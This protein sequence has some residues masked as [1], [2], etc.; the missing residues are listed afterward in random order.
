MSRG[1]Q[2]GEDGIARQLFRCSL[3][4]YFIGGFLN[5]TVSLLVP[6]LRLL[7][8]LSY[9]EALLVNLAFYSSYVIFALPASLAVVRLGYM[10][11]IAMGLAV[12]APGC[13]GLAL[14]Q[15]SNSF[16]LTLIALLVL[17]AGATALQIASNSV[18]TI[19]GPSP[20]AAARLTF[21]QAFNSLGT[22]LGPVLCAP[23]I[24]T[25]LAAS[26]GSADRNLP[27]VP[28][29]VATVGLVVLAMVFLGNRDL[30]ARAP[31]AR[32]LRF[33]ASAGKLVRDRRLMAG[34]AAIFAYVGAEVT[35]GTLLANYMMLPDRLAATPVVAGQLVGLYWGGAMIGRFAGAALLRR[36]SAPAFLLVAA[37][38]ALA[39]T[40]VGASP[41]QMLGVI[42]LLAVGLCNA[43][44][45]PTIFT[46]SLP[47]DPDLAALGS[48]WLCMA[49][50]GGAIV[51]MAS[52]FI[53][54]RAG[55]PVAMLVPGLCYGVVALFAWTCYCQRVL[56]E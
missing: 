7:L 9:G 32:Q 5:A 56:P 25:G 11:A 8:G 28:F 33:L 41:S 49:V 13:L 1:V 20:Q 48:M 53:A 35:I 21:L 51:P 47:R 42:A 46:L 43:I 2:I 14:V 23:L 45:Y 54:D 55:L 15:Q 4:V 52:G 3:G 50:V 18:T 40:V 16:P 37:F 19:V 10:R 39:L 24:L 26:A 30:L 44:M 29:A 27:A 12:M 22:V 17:S 31:K 34:V 38:A 6:R 36:A